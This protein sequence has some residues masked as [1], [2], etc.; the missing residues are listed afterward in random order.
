M[1]HCDIFLHF[2]DALNLCREGIQI[3][4]YRFSHSGTFGE[5]LCEKNKTTGIQ[6][7][8][9]WNSSFPGDFNRNLKRSKTGN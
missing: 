8:E 1:M 7:W 9:N 4:N 5:L 3:L 2:D 6:K